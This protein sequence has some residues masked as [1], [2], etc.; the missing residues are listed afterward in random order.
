MMQQMGPGMMF[1]MTASMLFWV[2]LVTVIVL[3]LIGACTWLIVNWLKNQRHTRMQAVP[4]PREESYA[5]YEQGY[6]PQ[7]PAEI[8]T[9]QEGGQHYIYPQAQYEQP[10]VQS[11]K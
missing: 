11:H 8:E 4:Q 6:Q 9:Y 10:Q 7:Q 2:V 3:L 1:G 5:E